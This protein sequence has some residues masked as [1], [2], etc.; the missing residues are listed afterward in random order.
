MKKIVYSDTGITI[1]G[2][3]ALRQAQFS[4]ALA[5]AP[6]LLAADGGANSAL[7]LGR[8]PDAVVGDID[9]LKGAH[10]RIP[11]GRIHSLA[12]Q[13][14]T[15]FG[16]CLYS[17]EAPFVIALG[18]TGSRMDHSL[19]A[20]NVLARHPEVAVLII[21]GDDVIF[22]CPAEIR[23][24]LPVGTRL[25]LFPLG[26]VSGHAAGLKWPID[27]IEFSPGGRIGTSNRT[28]AKVVTLGFDAPRMLVM[29][30][31]RRMDLVLAALG[32]LR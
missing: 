3:G 1:I 14:S 7:K 23:L 28:A 30:P 31:W 27:G 25:S 29:L 12:E 15:D 11:A 19:A 13:D 9:S 20:L 18:V 21:S 26:L 6:Y 10:D 22:I 8:V 4:R 24:D 32:V 2:G 17:L 5:L 16:K